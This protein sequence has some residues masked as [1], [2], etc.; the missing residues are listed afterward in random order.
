MTFHPKAA[1]ELSS[2]PK[3][4][5]ERLIEAIEGLANDPFKVGSIQLKGD[6]ARRIRVEDYRV[7]YEVDTN[8]QTLTIYRVRHRKNAYS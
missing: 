1:K 5:I 3:A 6:S 8:S 7:I 4:V 2:L